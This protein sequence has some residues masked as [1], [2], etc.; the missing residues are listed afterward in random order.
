MSILSIA[1]G[2]INIL[3]YQY[4]NNQDITEL[5]IADTVEEIG[6]GAFRG[7]TNLKTITQGSSLHTIG[8]NAF[9]R[10]DSLMS[11]FLSDSVKRVGSEAFSCSGLTYVEF[12]DND[13]ISIKNCAFAFCKRLACAILP[14]GLKHICGGTFLGCTNLKDVFIPGTVKSIGMMAFSEVAAKQIEL[15]DSVEAIYSNAFAMS[16]LTSIVVPNSVYEIHPFAFAQCSDLRS[17]DIGKSVVCVG[18]KAF[19]DCSALSEVTFRSTI[20]G[21]IGTYVF[22]GCKNL[23]RINVPM[24]A[25]DTYKRLLP[26]YLHRKLVGF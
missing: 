6:D 16:K 9:T 1:N 21:S 14:N 3:R 5:I 23:K 10:C 4:N 24:S 20:M 7:C 25:M 12:E 19:E 18:K 22:K 8:W 26:K 13:D 11:L 15:P 17:V 2:T